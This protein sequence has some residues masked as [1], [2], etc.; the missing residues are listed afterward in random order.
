[1]NWLLIGVIAVVALS[2]LYGYYKGFLR[3]L[4]SLVSM[5][6]LMIFVT[7]ASPLV[8]NFLEKHTSLEATI[9]E[10]CLESLQSATDKNVNTE[11]PEADGDGQ[12][13]LKDAG[14][15]IPDG[16]WKQLLDSGIGAAD[17][18]LEENGI[19]QSL[20]KSIAHFV[21][22]GIASLLTLV[23]GIILLFIVA[24]VLN[25]VAKL[26]VIREVNHFLGVISG[27]VLGFAIIW[28]FF[29]FVAISCT[30]TFGIMVTEQI[31]QSTILTWLYDNN[32]I[33][34]LVMMYL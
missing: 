10:R 8:S 30:S 18:M 28:L 17:Q 21:I 34:Y 5:I 7:V 20:A 9:E 23:I 33:L 31:R 11:I 4:F 26:P 2:V 22:N 29:Y 19:Y 6:V 16:I 14:I 1:M 3:I 27:L 24:R 13:L 32:M 12:Q 25:L 15:Q